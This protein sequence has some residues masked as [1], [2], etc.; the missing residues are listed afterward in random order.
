M[1]WSM[2]AMTA[3]AWGAER[4]RINGRHVLQGGLGRFINHSCAPNCE[5]QKW[6]ARGEMRI[7]LFTLKKVPAGTALT[8]DYNFARYG[9]KVSQQQLM[10]SKLAAISTPM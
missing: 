10:H 2:I 8:F 4:K 7:G 6:V 9:D 5:T 1:L 3:S